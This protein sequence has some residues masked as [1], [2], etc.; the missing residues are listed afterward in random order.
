[1]ATLADDA[2]AGLH[3]VYGAHSGYRA[4]HAKGVFCRG[5]FTPNAAA[6]GLTTAPHMHRPVDVVVRF[7]NASGSPA[8]SDA[9]REAR[10]LAVKFELPGGG[11]TDLLATNVRR[12]YTRTPED[13][14]A[15]TRAAVGRAAP[16]KLLRFLLGHRETLG[17][18]VEALRLRPPAS[19][20]TAA[21]NSLHS[22]RWVAP[23]GSARAL[24]YRWV[25]R[26][27]EAYLSLGEARALGP[28][29]L[30]EELRRRLESGP[31]ELDLTL[32]LAREGDPLDDPNAAWPEDREKVVVGVLEV[33]E[34]AGDLERNGPIVFDPTRVSDGIELSGDPV[35]RF[36]PLAYERSVELR[37]GDG[38]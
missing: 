27:G 38:A 9:S 6:A 17:V 20:A 23:D 24:R 14:V 18:V 19:Y 13:F 28:D 34:M 2:V 16:L 5:R 21:Y 8:I 29:Y 37:A 33:L 25:P 12:F 11:A 22:F 7:S 4:V 3:A 15:F 35:L 36:R 32:V 31:V 10:G 30:E 26:A 1:M